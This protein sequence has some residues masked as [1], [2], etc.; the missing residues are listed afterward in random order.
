MKRLLFLCAV[1]AAHHLH[2]QTLDWRLRGVVSPIRDAGQCGSSWAFAAIDVAES[3]VA[4]KT[5][6]LTALSPQELVDCSGSF[7]NMGCS[8]GTAANALSYI[9]QKGG[10]ST[11]ADYPYTA[12][13]GS[14]KARGAKTA[15][16]S[17][18][19]DVKVDDR[20]LL[21]AVNLGP[22]AVTI[23]SSPRFDSYLGG[24]MPCLTGP[25]V[26]SVTI[27]GY[28]T[29]AGSGKDYWL[30]KNSFGTRW[31]I[32][33]YAKLERSDTCHDIASAVT[34]TAR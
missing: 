9:L 28:G 32:G 31:G 27:I 11:S 5:G 8:G 15:P 20:S 1:L 21:A 4:L 33:G 2:A 13:D 18:V 14:C 7:H 29:E 10:L 6:K 34:A 26:H 16:L 22:V 25:A 30:I 24:V 12:R 19:T 3:A 17:A 23:G